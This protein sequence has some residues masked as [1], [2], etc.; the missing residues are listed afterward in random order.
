MKTDMLVD[1][2]GMIDERKIE[3]AKSFTLKSRKKML[4]KA[5]SVAAAVLLCFTLSVSAL[6]VTVD[7][8]YQILF[9]ILPTVA[10]T[11]KPVKLS[12]EDQGI[13][14]EVIS[15]AI[16]ENEAVIYISLQ[17]LTGNRIDE[18]TDLFD[19]YRINRPFASVA[20]CIF[21]SFDEETKTAT[22]LIHISQWNNEK[23]EGDKITF[24]FSEFLSQKNKFDEK[25]SGLDLNKITTAEETQ[26]PASVRGGGGM[27]P[28]DYETDCLV[29]LDGGM[30]SPVDGVTVTNAGFIDN[31]LHIQIYFEDIL[32]YDNHGYIDLRDE[33][34]NSV[35]NYSISFWDDEK[36]GSYDEI[37]YDISPENIESYRAYGYFV[38]CTNRTKGNWQVTFPLENAEY[39]SK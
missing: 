23:I 35:E 15:A 31:R 21:I 26:K 39:I 5:V 8:V 28:V 25:L 22:F 20:S 24:A 11:F 2:I 38:I 37:V 33:A 6:A 7:P 16:Y 29:P 27:I 19:S 9:N 1:A 34:G 36:V 10:Q 18:T 13:R 12:C 3:D 17:D 30:L 4:R 14:M 32:T